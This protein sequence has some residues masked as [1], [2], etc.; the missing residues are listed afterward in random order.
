MIYLSLGSNL[1][2]RLENLR[3]AVF[4]IQERCLQHVT[5]SIVLETQAILPPNA[6]QNWDLPY[7]NMIV[8]GDTALSPQTLLQTL[9][10]I[11]EAMGRPKNH[12][13]WSPRVIDIDI[14]LYD[15]AC[16][17]T[18]Y[19]TLPHPELLNRP[20]FLHLLALLDPCLKHPSNGTDFGTLALE[21]FSKT[22]ATFLRSFSLQPRYMG[23]VNVT[24]DS[25]SDGGLHFSTEAALQCAHQLVA[26]GASVID[27]GAQTT[28]PG[29]KQWGPEVEFERLQS[30][31][32]TW[33]NDAYLKNIPVSIDTYWPELMVKLVEQ[34]PIAWVNTVQC[35][36]DEYA[37]SAIAR[38][39]CRICV[40]HSLSIPPQRDIHLP[41]DKLP[42]ASIEI[43]F[44]SL[45]TRLR[46][47]GFEDNAIIF[48]PG[49]GFGKTMYQNWLLL[50]QVEYMQQW[51]CPILIGHSRK[52]FYE[53]VSQEEAQQRDLETLA[54]SN[55]LRE[56]KVD[57]LRVHNVR[58]HQ[59]F[60]AT[61]N[62]LESCYA[63]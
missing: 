30:V 24:P 7:L 63:H 27:L 42:M 19:L 29:S 12:P 21:A 6:S 36:L 62:C 33:Y 22:S 48:D 41:T 45:L 3:K 13:K 52:S 50:K 53:A 28:R 18:E 2:Q 35:P 23:V 4:L 37:L 1:G 54:I 16:L 55:Y 43:W 31:L 44:N 34:H 26:D 5:C 59:R 49:L 9:G 8:C 56:C 47:C 57:F 17:S 10:E 32:D 58:M 39:G 40:M 51:H 15:T 20:F 25:F 14:L 38:A 61:Q 11:E 60:F 46:K